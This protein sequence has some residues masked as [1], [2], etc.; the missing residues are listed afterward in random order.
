MT[1]FTSHRRQAH[2]VELTVEVESVD[3]GHSR[4]VVKH[5]LNLSKQRRSLYVI[6]LGHLAQQERRVVKLGITHGMYELLHQERYDAVTC[7]FHIDY[8]ARPVYLI[9]CKRRATPIAFT[10]VKRDVVKQRAFKF[11]GKYGGFI[12]DKRAGTLLYKSVYD[13]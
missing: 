12:V 4:N 2:A 3:I 13:T 10:L 8:I 9:P 5:G 7:K 6:L 1:L 11:A